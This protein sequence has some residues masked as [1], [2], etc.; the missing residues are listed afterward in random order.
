M[1]CVLL[2]GDGTKCGADLSPNQKYCRDCGGQV[3]ID[4]SKTKKC[5]S[6]SKILQQTDNFCYGC[7]FSFKDVAKTIICEG[8]NEDGTKCNREMSTSD[9][10]CSTCGTMLKK[11]DGMNY[12]YFSH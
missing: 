2:K 12:I 1:R 8:K 3:E 9:S 6:C 10:F 7:R 11:E 4:S 5:P